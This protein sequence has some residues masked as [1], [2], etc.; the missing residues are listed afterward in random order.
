MKKIG[1]IVNSADFKAEFSKGFLNKSMSIAAGALG[2]LIPPW[3]ASNLYDDKLNMTAV[4]IAV[5]KQN[6]NSENKIEQLWEKIFELCEKND[7]SALI[8]KDVPML[9][10][11]MK[12]PVFDGSAAQFFYQFDFYMKQG[13]ITRE[14]DVGVFI[15]EDIH[16]DYLEY[17]CDELNYLKFYS[18]DAKSAKKAAEY[19]YSYNSTAAE[20]TSSIGNMRDCGVV[21]V[22]EKSLSA[23][24]KYIP[25][26]VRV[27]PFAGSIGALSSRVFTD[28]LGEIAIGAQYFEA[29][30]YNRT[31]VMPADNIRLFI[32]EL[33]TCFKR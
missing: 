14:S 13:S 9:K 4:M 33:E 29:L 28:K 5:G 23:T 30:F 3:K 31:G 12:F 15:G 2:G 17:F 7:V 19:V 1:Y 8:V 20:A 18:R 10:S 22:L 26:E 32:S 11:Y 6:L 21:L 25:S 16:E 27:D 24:A